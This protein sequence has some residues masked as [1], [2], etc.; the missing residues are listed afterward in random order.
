MTDVIRIIRC[1][2][3]YNGLWSWMGLQGRYIY[4][5]AGVAGGAIVG[6][7]AAYCLMGFVRRTGR[8]GNCL[9]CG[10][11]AIILKQRKGL[12]QQKCKTWSVCVCLFAQSMTIRKTITA[13]CVTD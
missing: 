5:A 12:A 1:S 7:I 11:R 4:W 8:I 13:M 6:F 10:N 3:G 2:R 9:I